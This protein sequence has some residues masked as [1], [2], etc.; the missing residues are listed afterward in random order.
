MAV[1]FIRCGKTGPVKI[2]SAINVKRRLGVLQSGNHEKLTI[3]RQAP[4]DV[5]EERWLQR[6]F[7]ARRIARE[8]F[9]FDEQMLTIEIPSLGD[10]EQRGTGLVM[11]LRDHLRKAGVDSDQFGAQLNPPVCGS[12]VRKWIAGARLPR[13][14]QLQQIERLTGGGVTIADFIGEAA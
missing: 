6:H 10:P 5:P 9:S 3:L 13:L 11:A 14:R 8:W 1:Y 2:G 4:G 12:A 7:K